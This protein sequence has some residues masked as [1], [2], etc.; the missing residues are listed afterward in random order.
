MK[1]KAF[2]LGIFVLFLGSCSER[3]VYNLQ[4][5]LVLGEVE[6][7]TVAAR[8][9]GEPK[10]STTVLEGYTYTFEDEIMKIWWLPSV[11]M[12][13][14]LLENKTDATMKII[15]NEAAYV[16]EKGNSHKIIHAGVKYSQR[17]RIQIPS[18]LEQKKSLKDFIYPADYISF[19]NEGW[20]EKPLWSG[21]WEG[22][23]LLPASQKGG[24]SQEFLNGAKNY[25]GKTIQVF[26]PI[27]V[28][29]VM[30][31]YTFIF[32]V[33]DVNLWEEK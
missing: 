28:E 10:I 11:S 29:D 22:K 31:D 12:F 24:D 23:P 1:Y 32:K 19:A 6:R 33:R 20:V 4:Y 8:L 17:N 27:R 3:V 25:I 30:Y 21:Q 5:E 16:C 9:L 18:T 7:P 13:E 26:L 15:W 14:F 2:F